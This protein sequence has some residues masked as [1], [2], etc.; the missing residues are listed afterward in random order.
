M[1]VFTVTHS[2]SLIHS[3]FDVARKLLM[4]KHRT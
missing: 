2:S 3:K 1:S 4:T